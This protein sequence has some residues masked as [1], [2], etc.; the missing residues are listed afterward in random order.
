[1]KL[2]EKQESV[3]LYIVVFLLLTVNIYFQQ[4]GLAFA[5]MLMI[6]FIEIVPLFTKRKVEEFSYSKL[7][8]EFKKPK[9]KLEEKTEGDKKT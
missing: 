6:F 2:T 3:L 7:V 9:V 8:D 5:L 4:Y 1:M